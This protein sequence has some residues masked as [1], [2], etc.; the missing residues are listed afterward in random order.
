MGSPCPAARTGIQLP[1]AKNVSYTI[2]SK[3]R[4]FA[5]HD[6]SVVLATTYLVEGCEVGG[7]ILVDV[8]RLVAEDFP[9][10]VV[11]EVGELARNGE[12]LDVLARHD[13]CLGLLPI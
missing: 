4:S 9:D 3:P 12:L 13:D 5:A 7:A 1:S 11:E 10:E 8:L 2:P 6:L